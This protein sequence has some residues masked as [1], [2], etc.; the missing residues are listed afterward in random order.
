MSASDKLNDKQKKFC[1]LYVANLDRVGAYM[2][3]YGTDNRN[4]ARCNA[5]KLMQMNANIPMYIEELKQQRAKDYC[6]DRD[7]LVD[8]A[9]EI[10]RAAIKPKREFIYDNNTKRLEPTGESYMADPKAANQSLELISKLTGL[11]VAK[12]DVNTKIEKSSIELIGEQLFG[13]DEK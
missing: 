12:L 10:Y 6:I 2:E 1:E 13:S 5:C 4:T 8:K 3:A 7:F 11:N 9:M